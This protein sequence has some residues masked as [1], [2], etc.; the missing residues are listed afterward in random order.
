[1]ID[2]ILLI[3]GSYLVGSIPIGY[4]IA[5]YYGS[6]IRTRG[7]GTIGATNV[8]RLLGKKYFF[9]VFALD[10]GKAFGYLW[11]TQSYLTPALFSCCAIGLV[12]GNTRSLFLHFGGGK[13]VATLAGIVWYLSPSLCI[14]FFIV[15]AALLALTGTVGVASVGALISNM[16]FLTLLHK[17]IDGSI[18]AVLLLLSLWCI[19]LHRQHITQYL[20]K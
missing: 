2:T 1:M 18:I 12:L 9:L 10:A 4:L 15:W 3:L 16:V 20:H 7:S 8:A 13:G 6:D 14:L 19:Y 5:R 11:L 17:T